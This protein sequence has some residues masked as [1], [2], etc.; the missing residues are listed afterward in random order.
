ME[1]RNLARMFFQRALRWSDRPRYRHRVVGIWHEV[2]W[3]QMADRVRRMA[4]G[5]CDAGVRCGDRVGLLANSRPEW[6][7]ADLAILTIGAISVP[8]YPSSTPEECAFILWNAGARAIVVENDQQLTKIREIQRDGLVLP[9][10]ELADH[11]RAQGVAPGQRVPVPIDLVVLIDGQG[12]GG[13][14]LLTLPALLDRGRDRFKDH[15]AAMQEALET[16][17]PD[18][19]ATIVYTSGTTGPPKGVV[20]THG[21]HLAMCEM[22]NEE[23][24]VFS[25]G[26]VDFL[27]LPLAHSFARLQE[28]AAIYC[29]TTTAFAQSL[30]TVL[31]DIREARPHLIPSVPRVYE[32]IYA[33]VQS[34]AQASPAKRRV[35]DW[36]VHVGTR[37]S[38]LKQE[39]RRVPV[40]LAVQGRL[41]HRLVFHKLHDLFGG[42]LKYL[43]SGGAPLSRE[44][45]EFFHAAGIL[46][47][48][49]CGLTETCPALTINRPSAF[50]FGSVGQKLSRVELRLAPDGEL[51]AK[52][53]NIAKGYYKRPRAT[54]EAWDSD[55]W[56]HTG[57]IAAIDADGFVRI[58]DR[59]K[60]LIITASGKNIAPQ[61]VENLLKTSPYISQAMVFGDK[62]PYCVALVTLSPDE[63]AAW[64]GQRG[65]D[66]SDITRLVSDPDV[67][68]LIEA[69]IEARNQ[70]LAR[71]ET[72]KRFAIVHPDFTVESG[73]LTPSLKL[74]RRVVL[75]KHGDVIEALYRGS[76]PPLASISAAKSA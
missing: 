71:Y 43:V 58:V 63:I 52:G 45:A 19:T 28:Y 50:R 62:R 32:K 54:A 66:T 55:G 76:Q 49:G 8:I 37:I 33:R 27:F 60:E 18:D 69:E 21:N 9:E 12:D 73:E 30:D 44:V 35:F 17:G 22:V 3:K 29:G 36:A 51:L 16:V 7:E 2:S 26:D 46:V 11:D 64:A 23:V 42:R 68:A 41:A 61:N 38:R 48:E 31:T 65:K 39:R 59:K 57:D 47:L 67:R 34:Q 70:K 6:C 4:A 75:Q 40:A 53:P 72:V 74:K 10:V 24:G 1:D 56:F 14:D 15:A 13:D 20:Q 5:L 25:P